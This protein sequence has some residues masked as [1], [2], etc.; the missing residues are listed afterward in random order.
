M[1]DEKREHKD[2]PWER[3]VRHKKEKTHDEKHATDVVRQPHNLQAII[4]RILVDPVFLG[5]LVFARTQSDTVYRI[6]QI[7]EANHYL[8][9]LSQEET[10]SLVSQIASL[11]WELIQ[12][13]PIKSIKA[14][15]LTKLGIKSRY[16]GIIIDSWLID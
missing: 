14:E 8:T 2:E 16:K 1:S 13:M 9:G 3:A 10:N 11:R 12:D 4:V 15:I 6:S 7:L 5:K